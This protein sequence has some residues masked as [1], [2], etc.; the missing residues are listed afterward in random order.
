VRV[1]GLQ[2]HLNRLK[3]MG[4]LRVGQRVVSMHGMRGTVTHV[5]RKQYT[6]LWENGC[7]GTALASNLRKES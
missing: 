5:G 2:E 1:V 7:R 6:V 3:E 4:K